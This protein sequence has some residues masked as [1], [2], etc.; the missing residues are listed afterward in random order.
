MGP[1]STWKAIDDTTC[2]KY[3]L[4][5]WKKGESLCKLFHNEMASVTNPVKI[6]LI[7]LSYPHRVYYIRKNNIMYRADVDE[8]VT[9][10]F[11][12]TETIAVR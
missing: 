10:G 4:K 8:L 12:Q 9:T 11:R 1:K 3:P 7:N 2:Q 5:H 6:I